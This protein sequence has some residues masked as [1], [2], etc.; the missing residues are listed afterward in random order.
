MSRNLYGGGAN[1]NI[2]GLKFEQDTALKEAILKIKGYKIDGNKLIYNDE[3][4]G[5]LLAKH[6]LYK[7]FLEPKGVNYKE[8]ISKQLLPDETIFI[9]KT[10]ILHI[11]EKKFQSISGSVDEKLQT[12]G[13][14]LRQYEK[15]INNLN[16]KNCWKVEVRYH[17]ILSDWFKDKKYKDTLEYIIDEQCDYYFNELP[18]SVLNLPT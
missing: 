17:Y 9:Y 4:V 1:T 10:Q 12:C 18:M 3:P 2:N 14:K 5:L 15:L 11:I 16:E 8:I 6:S 7:V 13:F